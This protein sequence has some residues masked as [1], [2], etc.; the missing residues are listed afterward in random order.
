MATPPTSKEP[1][2]GLESQMKI[3][4]NKFQNYDEEKAKIV[5]QL[6]VMIDNIDSDLISAILNDMAAVGDKKYISQEFVM[7]A[8]TQ[9]EK[10]FQKFDKHIPA[11]DFI[12]IKETALYM[13]AFKV[14]NFRFTEM[15]LNMNKN[16]NKEHN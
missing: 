7:A 5:K 8:F 1:K 13:A 10:L 6:E 9:V 2:K 15:I 14:A 11:K 4:E 16:Q 3:I 12:L